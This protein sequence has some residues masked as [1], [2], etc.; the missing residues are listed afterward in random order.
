MGDSSPFPVGDGHLYMSRT[1][2]VRDLEPETEETRGSRFLGLFTLRYLVRCSQ[3][4]ISPRTSAISEEGLKQ[5][6][7]G[8][9]GKTYDVS[10]QA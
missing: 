1:R 6:F 9:S 8:I 4:P 10:C 7:C 5:C 3:Y 2:P